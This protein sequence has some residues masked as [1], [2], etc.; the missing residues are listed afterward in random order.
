MKPIHFNKE[1]EKLLVKIRKV[2]FTD[3][4]KAIKT[5]K[6]VDVIDHPN[7]NKYPNQRI[8]ILKVKNYII[9]VPFIETKDEIFLKTIYRSRKYTKKYLKTFNKKT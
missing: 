4:I 2:S 3:A 1:K 5:A 8:F 6:A 7:K 9:A